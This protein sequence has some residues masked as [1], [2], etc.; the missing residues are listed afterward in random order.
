[1]AN[2]YTGGGRAAIIAWNLTT[3]EQ[4]FTPQLREPRRF[5]EGATATG[6]F[7]PGDVLPAQSVGVLVYE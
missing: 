6:P 5:L 2:G 7:R 3:K 1:M 4:R